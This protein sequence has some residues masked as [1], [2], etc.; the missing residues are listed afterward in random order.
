MPQNYKFSVP[1][2][3]AAFFGGHVFALFFLLFPAQSG[4]PALVSAPPQIANSSLTIDQL[5]PYAFLPHGACFSSDKDEKQLTL[6]KRVLTVSKRI[7]AEGPHTLIEFKLVPNFDGMVSVGF[8]GFIHGLNA[9]AGG[10][11]LPQMTDFSE[12]EK[13]K[14]LALSATA[15]MVLMGDKG[16]GLVLRA[17]KGVKFFTLNNLA[18]KMECVF[19]AM[20]QPNYGGL[21]A[22]KGIPLVMQIL[23]EKID[24]SML[25]RLSME[26]NG[27]EVPK[28]QVGRTDSPPVIDGTITPADTKD[29]AEI[30]DLYEIFEHKPGEIKTQA[31]LKYDASRLYVLVRVFHDPAVEPS[32]Y[33][34]ARDGEIWGNDAI[35]IFIQPDLAK[36][37]V[38]GQLIADSNG[39]LYDEFNR[40]TEWNVQ[41]SFCKTKR[42]RGWWDLEWSLDLSEL[43][44]NLENARDKGIG[45]NLVRDVKSVKLPTQLTW[46]P[47]VLNPHDPTHLGRLVF[48]HGKAENLGR[49]QIRQNSDKGITRIGLTVPAADKDD[50]VEAALIRRPGQKL[51]HTKFLTT[52]GETATGELITDQNERCYLQVRSLSSDGQVRS[53]RTLSLVAGGNPDLQVKRRYV[54]KEL[55]CILDLTRYASSRPANATFTAKQGETVLATKDISCATDILRTIVSIPSVKAGKCSLE[56]ILRD[57]AGK[58]IDQLNETVDWPRQPEWWGS[59]VGYLPAGTVPDPWTPLQINDGTI[60]CWGRKYSFDGPGLISQ[61]ISAGKPLLQEPVRLVFEDKGKVLPAKYGPPVV[62]KKAPDTVEFS[63]SVALSDGRTGR[64]DYTVEFDGMV[65]LS[66]KGFAGHVDKVYLEIPYD[67]DFARFYCIAEDWL[68]KPGS[69]YCRAITQ[70]H[71]SFPF[72]NNI[73]IADDDRG[74]LWSCPDATNWSLSEKGRQDTWQIIREKSLT[75]L[76]IAMIDTPETLPA[77]FKLRF[78]FQAGPTKPIDSTVDNTMAVLHKVGYGDDKRTI[79]NEKLEDE[80][81]FDWLARIGVKTLVYHESWTAS[82]GCGI[83]ADPKGMRDLV[84]AAHARGMKLALYFSYEFATNDPAFDYLA[85]EVLIVPTPPPFTSRPDQIAY[86]YSAVGPMKDYMP[87]YIDKMMREFDIDGV[88]IDGLASGDNGNGKGDPVTDPP[89]GCRVPLEFRENCKRIRNIILKY[90]KDGIFDY[91]G[92][93]TGLPMN[94]FANRFQFGEQ[95]MFITPNSVNLL[96]FVPLDAFRAAYCG[97]AAGLRPNMLFY[98]L[99]PFFLDT[100]QSLTYLHGVSPR[101]H[102]SENAEPFLSRQFLADNARVWRIL[103]EFDADHSEFYP[104]YKN[105]QCVKTDD[106]DLKCSF[107]RNPDGNILLVVSYF[108]KERFHHA[109]IQLSR[110]ALGTAQPFTS[111]EDKLYNRYIL[112]KGDMINFRI[113]PFQLAMVWLKPSNP[114]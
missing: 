50:V 89:L 102:A 24:K 43:G 74:M 110:Q 69:R 14:N 101:T 28:I 3:M 33:A 58:K 8:Q 44:I 87:Y 6:G 38:Y 105:S 37:G 57:S 52:T 73:W 11:I 90:K 18:W 15:K 22:Q 95:F 96:D 21:N 64:V 46:S 25:N 2:G 49:I 42:H 9:A 19:H 20:P 66:V 103:K 107:Y 17:G 53:C 32:V 16:E 31:W 62:R 35:E 36:P 4:Y 68:R 80:N 12:K 93:P 45:F 81:L 114:K 77:N 10:E 51:L 65:L 48:C 54:H 29:S 61:I 76:R 23:V 99:S 112:V 67:R 1:G 78:I 84:K 70:N 5:S 94:S 88:Y 98:S 106:P 113:Q 111:G 59:Q 60:T 27:L 100:V 79:T 26:S 30:T 56:V 97:R 34:A 104:Y 47:V 41:K 55:A 92:N 83:P 71:Y 85:D 39:N 72:E 86:R 13:G 63:R 108:G 91:H 75:L 82:Q 40:K 7:S 109:Q